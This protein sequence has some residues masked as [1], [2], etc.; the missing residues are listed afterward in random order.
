MFR[1]VAFVWNDADRPASEAAARFIELLQS[2]SLEWQAAVK[3]NGLAVFYAGAR[4]GSSEAYF[5]QNDN[6]VVLGKLFVR[7]QDGR[8]AGAPLSLDARESTRISAT[9]GRYLIDALPPGRVER[10]DLAAS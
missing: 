8:W 5:L 6:G 7:S 9:G 10:P 3:Q 1:Y 4:A 2:G